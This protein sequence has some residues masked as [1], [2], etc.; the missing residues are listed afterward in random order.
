VVTGASEGEADRPS[1][2]VFLPT[3]ACPVCSS[4]SIVVEIEIGET[5]VLSC[6][7]CGHTS[8]QPG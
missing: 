7:A 3:V 5:P 2:I 6:T 1:E 8:Q 4:R